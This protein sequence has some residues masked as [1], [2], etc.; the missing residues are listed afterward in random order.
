MFISLSE[1]CCDFNRCVSEVKTSGFPRSSHIRLYVT[2]G[3]LWQ[4]QESCSQ[5]P[6]H[7]LSEGLLISK[8]KHTPT[9]ST[10]FASCFSWQ[11]L[12]LDKYSFHGGACLSGPRERKENGKLMNSGLCLAEGLFQSRVAH[13]AAGSN[14]TKWN[15]EGKMQ[16][17]ETRG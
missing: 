2:H 3:R 10:F 17:S 1:I 14:K 7:S 9:H 8:H 12:V 15:N 16:H 5:A 6:K 11:V 4:Q 13:L